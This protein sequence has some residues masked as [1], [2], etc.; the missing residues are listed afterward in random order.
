MEVIKNYSKPPTPVPGMFTLTDH[1]GNKVDQNS[2]AGFYRLVF[3]GFTHCRV[4]CPRN[5]ARLSR[6]LDALGDRIDGIR[7]LYISVDPERDTPEVMKKF[8]EINYPHFTGLTGNQEQIDKAKK[9]FRVFAERKA[10]PEDPGGYAVPHTAITYLMD[11]NGRYLTHFAENLSEE[12]VLER[13][14]EQL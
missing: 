10:D 9:A 5:L 7:P 1:N 14:T 13:L 11:R 6:I 12:E 8:L 4:I 2:Y 3:F